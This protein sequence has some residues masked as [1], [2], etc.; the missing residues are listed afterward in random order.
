MKNLP[1]IILALTLSVGVSAGQNQKSK[2]NANKA[3]ATSA[4]K[5]RG[6]IFRATADQIKRAQAILK[7]RNFYAGDQTGKLDTDTRA[8]LKKYQ[9]AEGLPVTGTLNK[10]TLQKM[11]IELTDK[12]K[13]M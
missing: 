8:A 10:L 13:S 5:N 11:S 1:L 2:K 12:Q 4:S 3:S 9:Q 7:E 6:P